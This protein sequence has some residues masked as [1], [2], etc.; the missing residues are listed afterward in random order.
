MV[1]KQ[2]WI[3]LT[4][5]L[6][7][8]VWRIGSA[9]AQPASLTAAQMRD[10]LAFLQGTWAPLD[11]SFSAE[12]RRSFDAI[13]AATAEKADQLSPAEFEFAVSRAIAVARNGHTAS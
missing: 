13:V 10:D 3:A 2:S 4:L 1:P 5:A 6:V 7:A 11:R 8:A 12:Q 9:V